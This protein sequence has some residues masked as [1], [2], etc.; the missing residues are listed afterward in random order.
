MPRQRMLHPK[1]FTDGELV[2]LPPLHR[3]LFAGLWCEADRAGRL[4]DRAV[5]LKIRLLPADTADVEAMLADLAKAG[6]I[7]RYEVDGRRYLA[8]KNFAT[9]QHPHVREPQSTIPEPP[10]KVT[11]RAEP[12][13]NPTK[14]VQPA[15]S[16]APKPGGAPGQHSAST[17]LAPGRPGGVGVGDRVGVGVGEKKAAPPPVVPP[18]VEQPLGEQLDAV[19]RELRGA[20]FAWK[21]VDRD[22]LRLLLAHDEAEVLRRWRIALAAKFPFCRGVHDLNREWNSYATGDPPGAVPLKPKPQDP[23]RKPGELANAF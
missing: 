22:A 6:L 2:S 5:D 18:A 16:M 15:P 8:V 4:V 11:A 17:G 1:F 7:V 14:P 13:S 21:Q 12:P 19:F 23:N 9:Y 3:L 10:G 20:E